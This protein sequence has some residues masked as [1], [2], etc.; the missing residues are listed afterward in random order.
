MLIEHILHHKGREVVTVPTEA[1]VA[2]AVARLH[3]RNI[4]APGRRRRPDEGRPRWW[5]SCPS[6]TSSGPSAH[7]GPDAADPLAWPVATLMSTDV[8]TCDLRDH[9]RRA[10]A[11]HDRPAHPPRPRARRRPTSP[12]S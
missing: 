3:E 7:A 5:A 9:R 6:V 10:D 1:T 11:A 12:A 2:E 4:G 8:A